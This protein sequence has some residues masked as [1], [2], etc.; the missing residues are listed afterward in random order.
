MSVENKGGRS[1][2]LELAAGYIEGVAAEASVVEE[3]EV[4]EIP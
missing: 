2:E 3:M 4:I 1:G